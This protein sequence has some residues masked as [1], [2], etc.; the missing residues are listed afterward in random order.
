MANGIMVKNKDRVCLFIQIKIFFQA[1]GSMAKN[2]AKEHM[3]LIQ[4]E[5]NI[6]ENGFKIDF[7]QEN[8]LIPTELIF[9]VIFK[10][11][12]QK[13]GEDGF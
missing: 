7:Y 10:I 1:I 5:W 9:R 6:L 4:L 3:Y 13:E 2:M 8:G 12:N 11:I